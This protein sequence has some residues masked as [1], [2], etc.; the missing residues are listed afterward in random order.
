MQANP[1]RATS[2]ALVTARG[3]SR[4]TAA[5]GATAFV[6]VARQKAAAAPSAGDFGPYLTR[7]EARAV[8]GTLTPSSALGTLCRFLWQ[9]GA[10][11]REAIQVTSADI[12]FGLGTVRVQ[13]LKR[14][15][16]AIEYRHVPIKPDLLGLIAQHIQFC[17]LGREGRLWPWCKRHAQRLVS[18]AMLAAG[19]PTEK[20]HCHAWRHGLAVNSLTQGVNLIVIQQQL[21][22]SSVVTTQ[23]YL[24][25][26][27]GDRKAAYANVDFD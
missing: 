21:G 24:R 16:G 17:G 26:T 3:E 2:T 4:I 6:A 15:S 19:V 20:A 1:P 8:L 14:K 12:D 7:D 10:R 13:T 11:I 23:K 5:K 18:G 9:S 22:H 27:L 25:V